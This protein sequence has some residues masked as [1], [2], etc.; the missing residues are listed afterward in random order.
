MV[1]VQILN[2]CFPQHRQAISKS[3]KIRKLHISLRCSR[4][5]SVTGEVNPGSEFLTNRQIKSLCSK[6]QDSR[7][8]NSQKLLSNFQHISEVPNMN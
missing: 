2:S 7:V 6:I 8:K 4:T 1:P 3:V 5:E